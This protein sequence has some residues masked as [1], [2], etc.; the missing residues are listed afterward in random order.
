[1]LYRFCAENGV[2]HQRISKLL[3]ATSEA[4]L[5][6]LKAIKETAEKNGVTDLQ[7]LMGNEARALEPELS[8]VAALLS[9][10]TGVIDSHGL[11]LA[12]EGHIDDARR[13]S[14]VADARRAHRDR[15]GRDVPPH[16]R[17]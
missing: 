11:M 15:A 1:M 9:P 12:L 6:K 8:C 14:G 10:S 2:P 3:V 4:Q 5:P 7:P 17:R 13:A 16:A